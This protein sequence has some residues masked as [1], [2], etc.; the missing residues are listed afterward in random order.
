MTYIPVSLSLFFLLMSGT[1]NSSDLHHQ[2]ENGSLHAKMLQSCLYSSNSEDQ[3]LNQLIKF[4]ACCH[5]KPQSDIIKTEQQMTAVAFVRIIQWFKYQFWQKC[6]T[7]NTPIFP[8]HARKN[9]KNFYYKCLSDNLY[10]S[11]N[12]KRNTQ[13]FIILR[14]D[15]HFP[16]R[17]PCSSLGFLVGSLPFGT[18]FQKFKEEKSPDPEVLVIPALQTAKL[19]EIP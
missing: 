17:K 8:M 7:D 18:P 3:S 4:S 19:E 6:Q 2:T 16:W 5:W 1:I 12:T 15:D 9:R 10:E 14:G 11:Q 13:N